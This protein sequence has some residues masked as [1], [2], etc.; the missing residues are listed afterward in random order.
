MGYALVYKLYAVLDPSPETL[1][2][3]LVWFY[4]RYLFGK[5]T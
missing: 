2:I 1:T 4:S 3:A 5:W